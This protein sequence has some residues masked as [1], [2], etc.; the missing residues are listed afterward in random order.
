MA[1][2]ISSPNFFY[3]LHEHMPRITAGRFSWKRDLVIDY[4]RVP[5]LLYERP[6]WPEYIKKH[7]GA[8]YDPKT[9]QLRTNDHWHDICRWFTCVHMLDLLGQ[10]PEFVP[11]FKIEDF[12]RA[13]LTELLG[14]ARSPL[15]SENGY[16]ASAVTPAF[17]VLHYLGSFDMLKEYCDID[18]IATHFASLQDEKNGCFRPALGWEPEPASNGFQLQVLVGLKLLDVTF[19]KHYMRSINRAALRSH[20]TTRLRELTGKAQPLC[21]KWLYDLRNVVASLNL[22][23]RRP[24][25]I[26]APEAGVIANSIMSCF[27]VDKYWNQFVHSR[28]ERDLDDLISAWTITNPNPFGDRREALVEKFP[29]RIS[30][31]ELGGALWSA[32]TVLTVAAH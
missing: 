7:L 2:S 25:C 21:D 23:D 27:G 30:P 20:L 12:S 13:V 3:P 16:S 22:L 18:E 11:E 19:D 4:F 17:T 1:Q 14:D 24:T 9:G 6:K 5:V 10:L 28:G 29:G 26:S 8:T 15:E 32:Y 31:N